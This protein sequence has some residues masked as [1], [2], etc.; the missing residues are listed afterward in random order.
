MSINTFTHWTMTAYDELL[1][2]SIIIPSINNTIDR[3]MN[4]E[5]RHILQYTHNPA[6]IGHSSIRTW[7][8][9]WNTAIN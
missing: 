2:I 7:I 1:I 9:N 6:S 5:I 8:D 3:N 4:F